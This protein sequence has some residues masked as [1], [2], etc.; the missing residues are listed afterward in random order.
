MHGAPIHLPE[1]LIAV[2]T[3][4]QCL[5]VLAPLAGLAAFWWL[6]G[7]LDRA[8]HRLFPTL[9]W[10][11]QLGWLNIKAERRAAK[12]LRGIGHVIHAVLAIA[13]FG[14]AWGAVGLR[15]VDQWS[16]PMVM[17]H[18]LTR[19]P[20][21]FTCFALWSFYLGGELLPR[22]RREY[23]HEELEKFRATLVPDEDDEHQSARSRQPAVSLGRKGAAPHG[24]NSRR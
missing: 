6:L 5:A 19:L 13:L 1:A 24:R 14:I 8:I 15:A 17:G 20:V 22:L 16:D 9:E 10:Q 3:A 2:P 12:V 23:E 11:R 18:L 21:L 7:W 4:A